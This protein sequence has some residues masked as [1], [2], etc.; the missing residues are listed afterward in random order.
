M[1]VPVLIL[2][3]IIFAFT[4]H[5]TKAEQTNSNMFCRD[6]CSNC[7]ILT[8]NVRGAM[9]SAGSLS[10]LLDL[11]HVDIACITE[12]KLKPN[13]SDF[14]NS[15]H[16]DYSAITVCEDVGIDS[17]CGKAG[18]S[19]LY[20]RSLNFSVN[21]IPITHLSSRIVGVKLSQ[22]DTASYPTYL[23]CVYMPSV[24]YCHDDYVT[25]LD[26]LQGLHDSYATRGNLI[27]CGDM[28]VDIFESSNRAHVF[29]NFV[30]QNHLAVM[31]ANGVSFT[32]RPTQKQ[33]DYVLTSKSHTNIVTSNTVL[34][35]ECCHVSDHLPIL[36]SCS[37]PLKVFALPKTSS[38]AWHK[39]T[40]QSL[41]DFV[42]LI[43]VSLK[44]V[45]LESLQVTRDNIE[46]L[47]SHIV[48]CINRCSITTLPLCKFNASAK[49]YWNST[50]KA[51]YKTQKTER[52]KWIQQGK[53]R[54][55]ENQYFTAYKQAKRQFVNAQ[56]AAIQNVN[57][58]FYDNLN[59]SAECDV[60]FFWRL[61][62][63]KTKRYSNPITEING[64]SEPV[65]I[66]NQFKNHY[67]NVFTP[68]DK[69]AFDLLFLKD[70]DD[71]VK[72]SLTLMITPR[73]AYLPVVLQNRNL[74]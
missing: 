7:T 9:S 8:W 62:H 30:S 53:P 31:A 50:V 15:I 34:N 64:H 59:K 68:K 26:T 43:D 10:F 52:T 16:S 70:L 18:V 5:I 41:S 25:C 55:R 69:P 23:F 60:K 12:H 6:N 65:E 2:Y 36:T 20:K 44:E 49:P 33:L 28:N 13:S 71:Q 57:K 1:A 66:A 3:L 38:I 37:I 61:Y 58:Q 73:T 40:P 22:T 29:N 72:P 27:I 11:Y 51:A 14:L 45:S 39:C 67:S 21:K 32:F 24:N 35:D 46:L 74:R 17:R 4:A 63:R 54:G 42:N 56:K 48:N 19:I 47:Y